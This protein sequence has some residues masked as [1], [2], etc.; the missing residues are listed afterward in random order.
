MPYCRQCGRLLQDGE[1]CSCTS[2]NQSAAG[3]QQNNYS[4]DPQ[5]GQYYSNGPQQNYQY[6]G[7]QYQGYPQGY[8]NQYYGQP[9]P[10]QEK[11]KAWI[12]AIIIPV[13][14]VVLLILGILAAI[15]VP[16]ML[17]YTKKSKL[18]NANSKANLIMKGAN[19]AIVE[20]E[21]SGAKVNGRYIIASSSGDNVAVPFDIGQF[22]EKYETYVYFIV[23]KDGA[24]EYVAVSED[25]TSK[26]KTIGT[27]PPS[28]VNGTKL[29][30]ADGYG[31]EYKTD[32]SLDILYWDAYDQIFNK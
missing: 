19:S 20:L 28:T 32:Q 24:V 30:S 4:S 26:K 13:G 17:G 21:E 8:P 10:P 31:T 29:Y 6:G 16:A 25:W 12:L 11:S 27:F 1:V 22:W 7:P 14:I 5:N 3:P 15:L 9:M 23:V 18:A 2:S